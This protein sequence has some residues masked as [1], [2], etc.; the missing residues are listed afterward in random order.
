VSA[1]NL[2]LHK[3]TR[4]SSTYP[5]EYGNYYTSDKAVDGGSYFFAHTANGQSPAYWIVD[6]ESNVEIHAV[7]VTHRVDC[8]FEELGDFDVEIF[9]HDPVD[10]PSAQA[11]LCYHYT[12]SMPAGATETL[13]C[14]QPTCGRYLRIQKPTE[15]L[16]LV[17]VEVLGY[18]YLAY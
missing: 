13:N 11:L 8:C 15:R 2:A 3:P 17:E 16:V 6:L 4:Q 7:K 18:Q 14:A 10:N 1:Q 12:G 5:P 9:C